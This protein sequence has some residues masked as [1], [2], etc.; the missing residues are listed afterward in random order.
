MQ[1]W[2]LKWFMKLWP[3]RV[4]PFENELE[5]TLGS[6]VNIAPVG[7]P[8]ESLMETTEKDIV[9]ALAGQLPTRILKM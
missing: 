2:Q 6:I 9:A 8:F 7:S 5:S 1:T 3:I 4:K